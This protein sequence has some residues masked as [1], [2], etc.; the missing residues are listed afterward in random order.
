MKRSKLSE[1][2]DSFAKKFLNSS[3]WINSGVG[4]YIRGWCFRRFR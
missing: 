3:N 1:T 2:S 4:L